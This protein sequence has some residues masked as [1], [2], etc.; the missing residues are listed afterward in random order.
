[1]QTVFVFLQ[2]FWLII[3]PREV[4]SDGNEAAARAPAPC[5]PTPLQTSRPVVQIA[6]PVCFFLILEENT[7]GIV[8]HYTFCVFT[9]AALLFRSVENNRLH[10]EAATFLHVLL[11]VDLFIFPVFKYIRT[12]DCMKFTMS[13][14][15]K[16]L[17]P[18]TSAHRP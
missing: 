13:F 7:L 11:P 15:N 12:A 16:N 3:S 5:S 14:P 1:V 18:Q 6:S 9:E 4:F 8:V 17:P 10:A 2:Q